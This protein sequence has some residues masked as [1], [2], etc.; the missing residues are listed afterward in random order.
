MA[1]RRDLFDESLVAP[2]SEIIPD[3][4]L[5][6]RPLFHELLAAELPR[7]TFVKAHDA[8][9]RTAAGPLFPRAATAGAIYLV[10]NP[11]DDAGSFAHHQQW[12]LDPSVA[13]MNRPSAHLPAVRRTLPATPPEPLLSWSGHVSSWLESALPVQRG[14]LRADARRPGA[15]LRRRRS[16]R[17]PRVGRASPRVGEATTPA[18]TACARRRKRAG[19]ANG[20]RRRRRS[21]GR[22]RPAADGGCSRPSRRA[23]ALVD[24]HAP[25]M[26]RF[27]CL[28]EAEAV[29]AA[30]PGEPAT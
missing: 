16:L 24:A 28:R 10:R 2:S 6:L 8:Y 15:R 19:S 29:S 17:L 21:S 4:I 11:C 23:R 25:V 13:L 22:G 18:P 9:I 1:I 14:A 26:E 3:E 5:R 12:S 30:R 27:G 20:S 7:P